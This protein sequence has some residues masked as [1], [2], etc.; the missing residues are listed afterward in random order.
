MAGNP[1]TQILTNDALTRKKWARDLWSIILPAT[2]FNS[3]IGSDSN[4]IIQMK[5]D[6]SKGEGDTLTFGIRLPL[7]GSGV[8]GND[9]VEGNEEKLIFKDFSLTIE[10]LNR[11]KRGRYDP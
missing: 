4:A 8:Q 1:K 6:L 2:E 5:T 7:T 3:L 9:P 10:E 11:I